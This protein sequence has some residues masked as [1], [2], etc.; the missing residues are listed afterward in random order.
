MRNL[1]IEDKINVS[2]YEHL[3]VLVIHTGYKYR[4]KTFFTVWG[5]AS[6]DAKCF[7]LID[8]GMCGEIG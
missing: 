5:Q 4:C 6:V 1:M 3:Y 7:D 2:V 8:T